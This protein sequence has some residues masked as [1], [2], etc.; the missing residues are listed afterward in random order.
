MQWKEKVQSSSLCTYY[1]QCAMDFKRTKHMKNVV[2]SNNGLI[3]SSRK[4]SIRSYNSFNYPSLPSSKV[5]NFFGLGA[6][7][8]VPFTVAPA[9]LHL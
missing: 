8:P 3:W 4:I 2:K 7:G 6:N 1:V 5:V 9:T